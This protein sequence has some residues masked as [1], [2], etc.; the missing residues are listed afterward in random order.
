M[1]EFSDRIHSAD[2]ESRADDLRLSRRRVLTA[3]IAAGAALALGTGQIGAQPGSATDQKT[4]RLPAGLVV[5]RK[6]TALV[7]IDPHN[8]VLSEKGLGWEL[9]GESVKENHTVEN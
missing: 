3:G 5:D 1:N 9:L 2:G 6:D 8:E 7:V 4:A